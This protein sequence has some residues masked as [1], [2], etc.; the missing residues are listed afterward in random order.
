MNF[1]SIWRE[2]ERELSSFVFSRVKD[3]DI[4]K[5]IMQ[6]VALKIF[7]SLHSQK[8]HIRG[9]IYQITKNTIFD[10][11]RKINRPLPDFQVEVQEKHPLSECL[12]PI[13]DSLKEG[14][15]EI[16]ELT[17]LQQYSLKEVAFKKDVPL[18]T[19]KSQLFR[20]KQSLNKKFFS[21]CNYKYDKNGNIVDYDKCIID[22][23]S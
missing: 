13:L 7:I 21:C 12:V 14:E 5:D 2:Y 4:H 23:K 6:E 16:L 9:W 19:V 3:I 18:N 8:K 15:K 1:E 20:A 11:Y 10:Y 17:Q 22:C